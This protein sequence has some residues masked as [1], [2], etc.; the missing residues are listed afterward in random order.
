[1][2]RIFG[3]PPF[4]RYAETNN[5]FTLEQARAYGQSL[6]NYADRFGAELAEHFQWLTEDA[7]AELPEE[8]RADVARELADVQIYLVRL[9]DKLGLDI[10]KAVEA[11]IAENEAKYPAERVRGSARK[12][13]RYD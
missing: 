1:M 3:I 4:V 9:A 13:D 6:P 12:Y 7:S 5:T 8:T 2:A 11:K 10:P